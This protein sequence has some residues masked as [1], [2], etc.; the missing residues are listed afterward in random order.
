MTETDSPNDDPAS[1][2][3]DEAPSTEPEPLPE[4][5]PPGPENVVVEGNE[6]GGSWQYGG[7]AADSSFAG[8][9][10]T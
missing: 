5:P 1:V 7:E 2:P 9:G 10:E 3:G 4:L 6:P 8:L